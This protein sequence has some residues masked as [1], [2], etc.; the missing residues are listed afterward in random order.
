MDDPTFRI[1]IDNGTRTDWLDLSK[2]FGD[3]AV[4]L[5]DSV[6]PSKT[7]PTFGEPVFT[8]IMIALGSVAA[9]AF[10]SWLLKQRTLHR[11]TLSITITD[12]NGVTTIIDFADNRYHEGA[13]DKK[14]VADLLKSGLQLPEDS[15]N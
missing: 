12:P 3:D 2:A 13:G 10:V 6:A 4:R 1:R 15:E 7:S 9:T 11:K 5:D 14:L 8:S